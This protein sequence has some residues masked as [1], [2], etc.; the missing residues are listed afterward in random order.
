MNKN[1]YKLLIKT[2]NSNIVQKT[3]VKFV[4]SSLSKFFIKAYINKFNIDTN[5]LIKPLN[6]YTSLN[7]FFTRKIDLSKRPISADLHHI[8]SPCDG[9]ISELGKI[10]H[11]LTF[12]IKNKSYKLRDMLEESDIS[13]LAG[14][15]Y[16][17]IYLSPANYHRFHAICDYSILKSTSYG[18]KS[19]PVNDMGLEHG[20]DPI[21]KNYRI[22][23]RIQS[24]YALS[25][26]AYIGAINVNSIVLSSTQSFTKGQETGY[27]QFGSS[28]MLFFPKNSIVTEV[29]APKIIK[30]GELIAKWVI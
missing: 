12:S 19:E 17:L 23:Q 30:F 8:I 2:L 24:V 4:N 20:N 16:M 26:I 25:Y 13:D 1:S 7:D 3:F 6:E 5:E 28:I 21:V 14:G 15:T 29:N 9:K 27:F 18:N 22:I 11:D 10:S